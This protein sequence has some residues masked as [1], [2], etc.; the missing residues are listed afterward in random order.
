MGGT[1]ILILRTARIKGEHPSSG[2]RPEPGRDLFGE[3]AG[4]YLVT[5]FMIK[6]LGLYGAYFYNNISNN[7]ES[8]N[9]IVWAPQARAHAKGPCNYPTILKAAS[10]EAVPLS[11]GP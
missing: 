8:N 11:R 6:P 10:R 7:N 3:P 2:F 5:F 9:T 1:V 4:L